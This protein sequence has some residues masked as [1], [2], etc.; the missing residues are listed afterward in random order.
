MG[1][2]Y[3]PCIVNEEK[4]VVI[5]STTPWNWG[6]FAKL[7]EH[8]WYGNTL[9]R[10][11]IEM[12]K[13]KKVRFAWVGDYSDPHGGNENNFYEMEGGKDF[14]DVL[15]TE[16]GKSFFGEDCIGPKGDCGQAKYNINYDKKCAVRLQEDPDEPIHPLPLLTADGN[17]RGGGDYHDG[18]F[19]SLVGSW[20]YDHIGAGD[21]VPDGFEVD[22]LFFHEY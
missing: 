12:L 21:E 11:A 17:G 16:N 13:G 3:K 6:C 1:Q 8:S 14:S 10:V 18:D 5:Y 22:T 9:V 15:E 4:T 19:L 2:Y 20:A 7:M